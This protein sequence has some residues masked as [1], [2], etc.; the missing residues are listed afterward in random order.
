MTLNF[1]LAI[2][3]QRVGDRNNDEECSN[4][5]RYKFYDMFYAFNHPIYQIYHEVEYNELR[6]KVSM[7]PEMNKLR[8]ENC[9]FSNLDRKIKKIMRVEI[10]N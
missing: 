8:K 9:S 10:L 4:A 5:G 2:Y 3:V 6:Q 7:P 1:A